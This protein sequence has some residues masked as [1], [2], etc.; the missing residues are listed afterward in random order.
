[1]D[2][3]LDEV[4][5]IKAG[6]KSARDDENW[7]EAVIDL[8]DA[9]DL[10][11][12]RIGKVPAS[13]TN[14][15]TSELADVL[16]IMGGVEKRWGLKLE[17]EQRRQHLEASLT[18]Y[19][20]GFKYE[21]GL[22]PQ[23][24]N[25]YNRVNRLVG[26]VL[27]NSHVLQDGGSVQTEFSKELREAA[28][29]LAEEIRSSRQKDPWAYCDLATIQLLRGEPDAF[30]ILRELDRLRPP[31]FVYESTL[32]TMEPLCEAAAELRPDLIQAVAQLRRSVPLVGQQPS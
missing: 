7:S 28:E 16:G 22:P 30:S 17:G 1:M 29:I 3:V 21:Q 31:Y 14:R 20:E 26:R 6:A 24:A 5:A 19:E 9:V 27:L 10:L 2:D 32:S 15:F 11:R 4:L 23:E 18:A 8:R 13:L 25:T 12:T